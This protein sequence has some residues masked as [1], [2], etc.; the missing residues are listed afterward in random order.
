MMST[1]P[2]PVNSRCFFVQPVDIDQPTQ[3]WFLHR[4]PLGKYETLYPLV[5]ADIAMV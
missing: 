5:M 1:K 4:Q 3:G 2:K